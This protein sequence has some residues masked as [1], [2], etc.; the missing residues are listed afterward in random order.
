M[1]TASPESFVLFPLGRKRFALPASGVSEL[2]RPDVVQTFPSNTRM[3]TGV[4][5]RRGEVI[6]V[7]DVAQA[8]VGK[9]APPR[10][11]YLIA[12]RKLEKHEESAAIPVSGDCE[13]TSSEL[14]PPT[15][16][17]AAYVVGLLSLEKEIVEVIDL[18]KLMSEEA[19]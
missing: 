17:L 13:L 19:Q 3:V 12:K 10:K 9:D 5:L 7:C 8:L 6:P 15:G 4:L 14:L 11:F 18:E 1:K 16:K 2:A